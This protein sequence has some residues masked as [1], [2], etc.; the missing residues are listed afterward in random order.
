MS[1]RI[2]QIYGNMRGVSA[3]T[4]RRY[5]HD[6]SLINRPSMPELINVVRGQIENVGTYY[7]RRTMTGSLRSNGITNI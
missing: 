2:Q 7:G 4:I 5:V 1:L 3:R 6:N